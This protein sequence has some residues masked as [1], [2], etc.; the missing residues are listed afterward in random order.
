MMKGSM[1]RTRFGT[2]VRRLRKRAGVSQEQLA[3]KVILSQS[4][5]SGIE[6]GE[7][8]VKEDQAEAIDRALATNGRITGLWKSLHSD[9]FYP[10]WFRRIVE[11]ERRAIEIREYQMAVVPGLVQTEH[12]ARAVIRTAQ[13]WA[14]SEKVDELVDARV[15]RA[16]ILG[17]AER[18]LVWFVLDEIVIRRPIG[19]MDVMR[20]QLEQLLALIDSHKIRVQVI[21]E[22]CLTHPGLAGPFRVMAFADLPPVA[23]PEHTMGGVILDA[24]DSVRQCSV[25]FSAL[26]AE[27]LPPGESAELIRSRR[28]QL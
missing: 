20:E 15:K 26:Q 21:P 5:L 8:A 18:P 24:E 4:M 14:P 16:E 11:M 19:G 28:E 25:I 27:A 3:R 9:G 23:Y 7:K 10:D 22:T 13:P 17:A 6:R 12:Y 1:S 2:E